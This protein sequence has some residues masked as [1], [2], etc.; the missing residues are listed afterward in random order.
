MTTSGKQARWDVSFA[1]RS[2]YGAHR[3]TTRRAPTASDTPIDPTERHLSPSVPS[4]TSLALVVP[5]HPGHG[6]APRSNAAADEL[7][8]VRTHPHTAVAQGLPAKQVC[9]AEQ[10]LHTL[11]RVQ[12]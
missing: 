1:H 7:I 9:V 3:M 12:L 8:A 4:L 10:T 2:T 6:L 5:S 11:D